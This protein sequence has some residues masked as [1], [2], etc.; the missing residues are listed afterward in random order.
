[1][2]CNCITCASSSYIYIYLPS[3]PFAWSNCGWGFFPRQKKMCP[4]FWLSLFFFIR[5]FLLR[6]G[7][8][9]QARIHP[10]FVVIVAHFRLIFP[11]CTKE[12]ENNRKYFLPSEHFFFL[13]WILLH[14]KIGNVSCWPCLNFS[15]KKKTN[16]LFFSL[17]PVAHTA[18]SVVDVVS[19]RQHWYVSFYN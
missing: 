2:I 3:N 10:H 1:M 9:Q 16:N 13:R 17:R 5:L 6:G 15:K 8:G 18:R 14:S 4:V 7:E 19:G 11:S 12:E